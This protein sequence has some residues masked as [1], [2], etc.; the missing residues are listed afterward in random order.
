MYAISA[1]YDFL[2]KIHVLQI[3]SLIKRAFKYGYVK[4]LYKLEQFPQDYDDN[5]FTKAFRKNHAMHYQL[6]VPSLLVITYEVLDMACRPV[7]S[8]LNCIKSFIQ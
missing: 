4:S 6:P 1:S 5:L 8:N 3:N 7:L 2:N